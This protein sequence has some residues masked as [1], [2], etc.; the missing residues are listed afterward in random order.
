MMK[1]YPILDEFVNGPPNERPAGHVALGKGD[2]VAPAAVAL[3][4]TRL[5][6]L[7]RQLEVYFTICVAMIVSLFLA[8]VFLVLFQLD[9]P[10][11]VKTAVAT[12]G[13]TTSGLIIYMAWLWRE[14]DRTGTIIAL[15]VA[16]GATELRVV[17]HVMLKK[18]DAAHNLP[19]VDIGSVR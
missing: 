16:L 19:G 11:L 12:C 2:K 4:E 14:R 7:R 17:L 5:K 10:E 1:L 8:Q 9:R 15:A 3:L 18:H 6:D 13:I